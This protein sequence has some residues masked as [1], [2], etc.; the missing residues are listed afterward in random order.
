MTS[1]QALVALLA[2]WDDG[3]LHDLPDDLLREQI[4]IMLFEIMIQTMQDV[5]ARAPWGID[6]WE[7]SAYAIMTL[8]SLLSFP[9]PSQLATQVEIAIN[10]GRRAVEHGLLDNTGPEYIWIGKVSY[11]S[12]I[13]GLSYALAALNIASPTHRLGER[14]LAL[15]D[16]PLRESARL[17]EYYNQMSVPVGEPQWMVQG[18]VFQSCLFIPIL[19]RERLDVFPRISTEVDGYLEI[20]LPQWTLASHLK[21]ACIPPQ[22]LFELMAASVL[23]YAVDTF[24]EEIVRNQHQDHLEAVRDIIYQI[25]EDSSD[26]ANKTNG[27]PLASPNANMSTM[28]TTKDVDKGRVLRKAVSD[29]KINATSLDDIRTDLGNF[30]SFVMRGM[31]QASKHDQQNFRYYLRSFLL[32]QL[33]SVSSNIRLTKRS[34]MVASPQSDFQPY[35][36]WVRGP[37]AVSVGGMQ[38]FALLA[39][40]IGQNGTDCFPGIEQKF[41]AQDMCLHLATMSRMYN[42]YSSLHRDRTEINLNSLDF[43]EFGMDKAIDDGPQGFPDSKAKLGQLAK[44]E[45]Q[46]AQAA[47]TQL[48]PMVEPRVWKVLK[49]FCNAN[50]LF[51]QLYLVKDLGFWVQK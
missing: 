18:S 31:K 50:D 6:S 9:W 40:M 11:G 21:D 20:V 25:F 45:W 12:P 30:L 39:G 22:V 35:F 24:V 8:C 4:P 33:D 38:M 19:N 16:L 36:E 49:G 27:N 46:C 34:E 37:A 48:N 7:T 17:S 41:L 10:A 32:A 47:L 51:R 5:N 44:Y 3:Q 26:K 23:F 43:P 13:L 15:M 29:D 42:D 28:E 1:A 2:C 14:V